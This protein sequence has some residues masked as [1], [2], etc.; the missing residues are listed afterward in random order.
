MSGYTQ[1]YV[2]QL[3]I[4]ARR[5]S[6]L[7]KPFTPGTWTQVVRQILDYERN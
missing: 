4:A 3:Q 1:P 5:A 2:G 6:F 7:Q